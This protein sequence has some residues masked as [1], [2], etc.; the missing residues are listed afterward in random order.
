MVFIKT[1]INNLI[2][3]YCQREQRIKHI[4]EGGVSEKAST[5]HT[6]PSNRRG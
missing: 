1:I 4:L 3:L 2:R 5:F 6:L